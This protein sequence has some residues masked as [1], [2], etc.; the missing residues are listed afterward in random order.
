MTTVE[1]STIDLQ[2]ADEAFVIDEAQLAAVAFLARSSGRTLDAYRHDLRGLFQWAATTTSPYSR[3]P[4]R[5]LRRCARFVRI[6]LDTGVF[7]ASLLTA[8]NVFS[9]TPGLTLHE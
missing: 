5:S 4:G 8:D 7:S 1:T 9:G 3:R 2:L 6:V